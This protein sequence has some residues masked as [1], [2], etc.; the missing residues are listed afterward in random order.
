MMA[1]RGET[2]GGGDRVTVGICTYNRAAGLHAVLAALDKQR[3]ESLSDAQ[4][5]IV[6]VDNSESGSARDIVAEHAQRARFAVHYV[7]ESRK[8]LAF[9]R[10]AVMGAAKGLHAT[11]LAFVDDDELPDA[12]WLE[13]LLQ[14]LADGA[15]G[16]AIGPVYPVFEVPPPAWLP[17]SAFVIRRKAE[18]GRVDDGYTCNCILRLPAVLEAGLSFDERFNETGGEDT[19]FFK[20][21]REKG[22]EIGW[23]EEAVVFETVPRHRMRAS[24]LWRRWFRT[25]GLEVYLRPGAQSGVAGR[26]TSLAGGTARLVVGAGKVVAGAAHAGLGQRDAFVASFYTLC[27]G[28]GLIAKVFGRDHREYA[29]RIYR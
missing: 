24:W 21:L 18:S 20:Q 5:D 9:A 19:F 12:V 28:A 14:A 8:G 1:L 23:C 3:L 2:N 4:V 15:R 10:N 13:A 11:Y 26:L 25:G 7:P 22:F 29:A 6:V 27:R 16:A 17:T